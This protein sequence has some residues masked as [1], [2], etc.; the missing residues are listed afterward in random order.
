MEAPNHPGSDV[1]FITK[2]EVIGEVQLK[3][4]DSPTQV[5]EHLQRYPEIDVLA[6]DEVA[7]VLD[8][9]D[10]SG[11]SNAVLL[12]DVIDRLHELQ[13]MGIVSE[14]TDTLATS[15]LVNSGILI[16]RVLQ[17]PD[18]SSND[19]KSYLANAEIAFGTTT[20]VDGALSLISN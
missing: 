15:A 5:Y 10:S 16:F 7:S 4:V 11:L 18:V 13:E 20:I 6:T 17:N 9:V 8:G 1:Q 2:R 19:F 3:A 12:T 14:V